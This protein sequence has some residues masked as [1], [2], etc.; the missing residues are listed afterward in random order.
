M[1]S[2]LPAAINY[3]PSAFSGN[4]FFDPKKIEKPSGRMPHDVFISHSSQDKPVADAV[5]AALENASI[6]CWIAPRDVQP[7][8]SFAGE[9]TRAI[10]RSKVMVLI[11]SAYSN[12]SEQVLREVQLAANSH[13]HIVQFRIADV[14]P[15]D[16]LEYY[17]STPHWLDALTPP[18]ERHLDR[19]GTSIKALLEMAPEDSIKSAVPSARPLMEPGVKKED[20]ATIS[21][22]PRA[23][24]TSNQTTQPP[25]V[26]A[27]TAPV[28]A[29]EPA[30]FKTKRALWIGM[31]TAVLAVSGLVIYGLR[32][33]PQ[34]TATTTATAETPSPSPAATVVSDDSTKARDLSVETTPSPKSSAV[35]VT[36]RYAGAPEVGRNPAFA[37][38]DMNR[39]FKEY[40]KTKEAE[41]SINDAKNAAKK[42]YDDRADAYKKAL[43]EINGLN[44][45]LD[46]RSLSSNARTNLAKERDDKI[47]A[48]KNMEREINEFRQ[49]REK[50]LRDQALRMR[51]TL[52]GEI[53][54]KIN[55]SDSLTDHFLIDR[56]G[57][58]LNGVPFL[59]FGPMKADMSERV[60]SA[61]NENTRQSFLGARAIPTALV[62]MNQVFKN[63]NKTKDAE[64]RINEAKN[65]AKREYD[66]R[67]DAYKKELAEVNSLNR[68]LDSSTLK[69]NAKAKLAKERDKIADIKKMEGEIN[70]F[71][72]SREKQLREQALR[73]REGL[74]KDINNFIDQK[75][76]KG[77]ER[78]VLDISG[79][80]L[81]G[82]Q[83]AVFS[84]GIPDLSNDIIAGLNK[85]S[86]GAE[87]T[88]TFVSSDK[89]R[90]AQVDANR[91]FKA[92]PETKEAEA[93]IAASKEKAK[94]EL[95]D[96]PS[97][98]ARA[99]KDKQLE[100]DTAEKRR[101][102]LNKIVTGVA[103][104]GEKEGFNLIFDASGKSLNGV[105][106]TIASRD[107]PDITAEVIADLG[108]KEE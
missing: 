14:L 60:I 50:E 94:A 57:M 92:L 107:I 46:T 37:L 11:F 12:T 78:M 55:E 20:P 98:D 58:S 97:A 101:P 105:P 100:A 5:C 2:C 43:D 79:M 93:E 75:Y 90:F 70:E 108:G 73:L 30:P 83:W 40:R 17:L 15:N 82:V 76:A 1:Q 10:Q 41:T 13:L 4:C 87:L 69:P 26:I 21:K 3:Q 22:E 66:D 54:A 103:A 32:S 96:H 102:L 85:T 28:S 36:P 29:K 62:D 6:R 63:Y 74:V 72:K 8:R 80:T 51:E 77:Q 68:Q 89:L 19:L 99:A 18:L 39:I 25:A 47:T 59:L 38:V 34:R 61:L 31:A 88:S 95:G 23:P 35:V 44:K 16:D 106:V 42:E 64:S 65:A 67:A 49:T 91:V 45:Q 53:T 48:I 104:I 9:I 71:R 86:G 24:V 33:N 52:V 7:G 27:P 84:R 81:N 56:S